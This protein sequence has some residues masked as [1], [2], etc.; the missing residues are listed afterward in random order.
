MD[1]I[2]I[3]VLRRLAATFNVRDARK[4]HQIARREFPDDRTLTFARA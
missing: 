1:A 4:L 2:G 3:D